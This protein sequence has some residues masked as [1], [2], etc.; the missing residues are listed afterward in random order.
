[1]PSPFPGM[2]PF[3]EGFLWPDVHSTLANKIRQSL[4]PLLRPKYVVRLEVS[5]VEDKAPEGEIGVMYPDVEV[6]RDPKS[7]QPQ[8]STALGNATPAT[9]TIPVIAP[10]PVKLISVHVLD[11]VGNHLVTSLEILSPV[12]KHEPGSSAYRQKRQRMIEAG[13]HLIELDFLLRGQRAIKHP[14]LHDASYVVA[15]TRSG[16]RQTDVWTLSIR[17]VLP[18]I[19]VPLLSPDDDVVLDLQSIFTASY[20]EAGYDL[21]IDYRQTP[22]PPELGKTDQDFMKQLLGR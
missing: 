18:K 5:V 6:L 2:D 3:L 15:L 13:V 1:M 7:N 17:D 19:P 11:R 4:A 12:N 14:R 20:D 9:L 16:S 10:V 8:P 21:S 22:P